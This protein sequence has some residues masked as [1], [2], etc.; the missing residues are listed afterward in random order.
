MGHLIN[1]ALVESLAVVGEVHRERHRAVVRTGP[2]IADLAGN[3]QVA[4]GGFVTRH[5]G[6]HWHRT[7]GDVAIFLQPGL[8]VSQVN[9]CAGARR[10]R[11]VWLWAWFRAW[12]LLWLWS[13]GRR[14]LRLRRLVLAPQQT[15]NLVDNAGGFGL[16]CGWQRQAVDGAQ[17]LF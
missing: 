2:L 10:A 1:R 4:T 14:R 17:Q 11:V 12:L 15:E 16:L 8:L 6:G 13:R 7:V 3:A 5:T 9:A